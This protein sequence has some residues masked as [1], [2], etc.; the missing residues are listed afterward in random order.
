M[1]LWPQWPPLQLLLLPPV[2]QSWIPDPSD[3]SQGQTSGP[4]GISQRG[5][6]APL[7]KT[8]QKQLLR[9]PAKPIALMG[10]L[11]PLP[12]PSP[13]L[14][15][16]RF[17]AQ[18]LA[19]SATAEMLPVVRASC[20]PRKYPRHPLISFS[21]SSRGFRSSSCFFG[22]SCSF[23]NLSGTDNVS[24]TKEPAFFLVFLGPH[25][26]HTE[27]PRLGGESDL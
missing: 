19:P 12:P 7:V 1:I 16:C 26:R 15:P 23:P 18:H 27:A 4:T 9:K 14:L 6:S 13:P 24:W 3:S 2:L 11:P 17:P 5:D 21:H 25:L 22:W 20:R 10:P 8:A